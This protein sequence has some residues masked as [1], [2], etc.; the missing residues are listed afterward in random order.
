MP[1]VDFIPN[2][3]N[4]RSMQ[5]KKA[6][7]SKPFNFRNFLLYKILPTI[8]S[9]SILAASLYLIPPPPTWRE[10]TLPQILEIF[11][12]LTLALMFLINLALSNLSRSFILSLCLV[13]L[14]SLHSLSELT[15]PNIILVAILTFL[16]LLV[17][18]NIPLTKLDVVKLGLWQKLALPNK[19]KPH[20]RERQ[21]RKT[22]YRYQGASWRKKK[23]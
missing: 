18:G 4:P 9:S 14:L 8:I 15:P 21:L 16:S 22:T 3:L 7:P 20:T 19:A 2:L 6:K 13:V 12:P 10:A 11:L 5:T 1:N 23:K 17:F